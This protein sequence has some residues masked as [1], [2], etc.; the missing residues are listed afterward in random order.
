MT[1]LFVLLPVMILADYLR[2]A[3]WPMKIIDTS[4]RVAR[5]GTR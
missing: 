2:E 1:P 4:E 5:W 3:E